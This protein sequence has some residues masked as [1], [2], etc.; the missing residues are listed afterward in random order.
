MKVRFSPPAPWAGV[1]L[2]APGRRFF[3]ASHKSATRAVSDADRRADGGKGRGP[4]DG[5]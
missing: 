5:L 2:F 3:L 4:A 1:F